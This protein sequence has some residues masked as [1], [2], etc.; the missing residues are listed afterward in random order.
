MGTLSDT[1][2]SATNRPKLIRDCTDMVDAEVASKGLTG[3][4]IKAGYKMVKAIKPTIIPEVLDGLI[5]DM[6]KNLE[7]FW[8]AYEKGGKQGQFSSYLTARSGEVADALLKITDDRAKTTSHKALKSAYE[9]LRPVG[10]KN[11]EAAV[12]RV[13]GVVSKFMV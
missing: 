13:A 7:H 12:P 8:E 2:L 10:K 4:P 5:N 9:Q 1:L 6:V 11:V 3:L